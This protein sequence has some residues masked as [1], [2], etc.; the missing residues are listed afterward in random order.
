MR[1]VDNCYIGYISPKEIER[2]LDDIDG[3]ISE[4]GL[5]VEFSTSIQDSDGEQR[6]FEKA[7]GS[8]RRAI[9]KRIFFELDQ[10]LVT[11]QIKRMRTTI[12]MIQQIK[13]IKVGFPQMK[14]DDSPES[15]K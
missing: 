4:W 3:F 2:M 9:Q 7:L 11:R 6:L 10:C 8:L 12:K 1:C 13:G 5:A 14:E 15:G